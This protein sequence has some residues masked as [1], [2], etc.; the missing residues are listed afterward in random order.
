MRGEIEDLSTLLDTLFDGIVLKKERSKQ[1]RKR[2][3][4]CATE[5]ADGRKMCPKFR[6]FLAE[7]F[8]H[9]K[10][11]QQRTMDPIFDQQIVIQ[12]DNFSWKVSIFGLKFFTARISAFCNSIRGSE[13]AKT[14]LMAQN[15]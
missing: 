7:T 13:L 6:Q 12:K 15:M 8:L 5:R 9:I 10:L 4:K 14:G 3:P 11:V 2:D 1:G